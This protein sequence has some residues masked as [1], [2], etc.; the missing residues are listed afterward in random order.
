MEQSIF[1]SAFWMADPTVVT[2]ITT[3]TQTPLQMLPSRITETG[4]STE[5]LTLHNNASVSTNIDLPF[6]PTTMNQ[7]TQTD[8]DIRIVHVVTQ[9][10]DQHDDD[11]ED[12]Q[13]LLYF[14]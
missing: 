14:S 13:F 4:T 6:R 11:D 5:P 10:E 7:S 12:R 1:L 8:E 3:E 9:R 2:N